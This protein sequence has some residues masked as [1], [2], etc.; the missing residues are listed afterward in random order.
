[1]AD[2]SF[3]QNLLRMIAGTLHTLTCIT[4]AREMFGKS[5]FSL[6]IAEKVAVDNAVR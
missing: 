6:G 5:Y 2:K 3:E 1:M 4:A